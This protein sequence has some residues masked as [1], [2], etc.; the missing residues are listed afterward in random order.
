MTESNYPDAKRLKLNESKPKRRLGSFWKSNQDIQALSNRLAVQS[1]E[2]SQRKDTEAVTVELHSSLRKDSDEIVV[3][4]DS[5]TNACATLPHPRH[6]CGRYPFDIEPHPLYCEKCYCYVCQIPAS[7]CKTW[8]HHCDAT[9]SPLWQQARQQ[10]KMTKQS[11]NDVIVLLED[12]DEETGEP[13]RDMDVSRYPSSAHWKELAQALEEDPFQHHFDD[14]MK[15]DNDEDMVGQKPRKE[16]RITEVLAHNLRVIDNEMNANIS[17]LQRTKEF[18]IDKMSGDVPDLNLQSSFFVEGVKIGWPY[19]VIMPPQRQMAIHLTK[20]FKNSR[21]CVIESPTGT[22]KS[23]AILCSALA[24]QRY[25]AKT[26]PSNEVVKIIYCSRTHSQVGQMVASLRKTPYRPRMAILGSRD[27]LC[28]HKKL[29]PRSKVVGEESVQKTFDNINVGC[30]IRTQNV[31]SYRRS[32]LKRSPMEYND[33]SPPTHH[34]GDDGER[35]NALDENENEDGESGEWMESEKFQTCPHYRQ[36]TNKNVTRKIHSMFVPDKQRVNCCSRGGEKSKFGTHDIEDLVRTGMNPNIRSG[37]A[38]YRGSS[39]DAFGITMN[40]SKSGDEPISIKDIRHGSVAYEE[41]SLSVGDVLVSVNGID[42]SRGHTILSV[43]E[44]IRESENPLVL[45]AY[46]RE[47]GATDLDVDEYS[48]ESACP[49]Y[50]SKILSKSADLVFCPYNYIL[51]PDIRSA[52]ELGIQNTIVILDEAHNVEDTLR[53]LGS[54]KFGEIELLKMLDLLNFYAAKW[55]SRNQRLDWGRRNGLDEEETLQDRIPDICHS[56]LLFLEPILMTMRDHKE[57][58]ESDQI[59]FGVTKAIDEYERFKSPD[60]KEFEVRYFGPTGS[61]DGKKPIGCQRFFESINISKD[62]ID[63]TV[64]N[65][66]DFM[67]FMNTKRGN[68]R[69][70]ERRKLADRVCK[71]ITML[72]NSFNSPE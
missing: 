49:Y 44:R 22:G 4:H 28:I 51:D 14:E 27:R 12:S 31:E 50:L 19:P 40:Q 33:D 25:H 71:L 62:M 9:D 29:R 32:R 39:N 34:P 21:H 20:A 41:G 10:N 45:D 1:Q 57:K 52:M 72:C 11:D 48:E 66:S 42:V 15:D 60:D 61:G 16:A 23:A 59:Q 65:I 26:S 53:S 8:I 30:Q 43:S 67:Q 58:F 6:I 5:V 18:E 7:E 36:L 46:S 17:T 64:Q 69:A 35:Q 56:L 55:E 54:D 70:D 2:F 24:W 37:V 47:S 63:L 38:L 13:L 68:P 3:V